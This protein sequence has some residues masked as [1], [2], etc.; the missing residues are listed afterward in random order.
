MESSRPYHHGRLREALLEQA[1]TTVRDGG[2]EALS[3]RELARA[4]GVSHAAP[5]R[6]FPDRQALL[7]ALAIEGF[8]RLGAELARAADDRAD[9]DF[10]PTMQRCAHAYV[11]FATDDAALLEL[12]FAGKRAD[13]V[14][15][16]AQRAFTPVLELILRGQDEGVFERGDPERVGLLLLST[17][18]GIASLRAA[19][20]IASEHLDGLVDDAIAHFL[21]GTRSMVV[22][23]ADV[24]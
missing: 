7:D 16:A 9:H 24:A 23:R 21:R 17:L 8:G 6:H 20:M 14:D 4:V 15:D 5:R 22:E 13:G 19:G 1:M 10:Q 18:Q 11:A 3:L 12:M 2:V